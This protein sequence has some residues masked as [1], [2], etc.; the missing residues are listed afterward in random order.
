MQDGQR[1]Y[2]GP[3]CAGGGC[4]MVREAYSAT[5]KP[6]YSFSYCSLDLAE[7][8]Q[9]GIKTFYLE[10]GGK[11]DT[12]VYD[13]QRGQSNPI[14]VFNGKPVAIDQDQLPIFPLRRLH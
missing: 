3:E 4:T 2:F 5:G 11:T 7:V 9:N 12:L 13:V 10:L 6:K 1:K 8:S 14:P